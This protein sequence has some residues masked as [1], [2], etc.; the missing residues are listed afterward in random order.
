MRLEEAS[1]KKTSTST[2]LPGRE[3]IETPMK[4]YHKLSK[5]LDPWI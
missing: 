3:A 5:G 1:P 4:S 2:N